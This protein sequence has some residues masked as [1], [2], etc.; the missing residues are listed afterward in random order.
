[1]S[2]FA[3]P[4]HHHGGHRGPGYLPPPPE[5]YYGGCYYKSD[6]IRLAADIVSLVRA[7]LSIF[8]PRPVIVT[9]TV[10]SVIQQPVVVKQPRTVW[11]KVIGIDGRVYY[12]QKTINE[13]YYP[14]PQQ[15]IIYY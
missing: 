2:I 12:Y 1:M 11:V 5:R 14:P 10:Q 8:N 7:G 3:G 9:T 4:H 13:Q 15:R 6:E